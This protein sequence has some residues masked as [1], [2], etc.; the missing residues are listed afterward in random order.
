MAIFRVAARIPG[1]CGQGRPLHSFV[2]TCTHSL[3]KHS[4]DACYMPSTIQ[5]SG[6]RKEGREGHGP[7]L[8]GYSGEKEHMKKR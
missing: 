1:D 6:E 3:N 4:T 7:A 5:G 8:E 2:Y